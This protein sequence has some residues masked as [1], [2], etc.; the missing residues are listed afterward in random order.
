MKTSNLV[1]KYPRIC[2]KMRTKLTHETLCI[3]NIHQTVDSCSMKL[4]FCQLRV[5]VLHQ[6]AVTKLS[7]PIVF[8]H[9][10]LC[11]SS[12]VGENRL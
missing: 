11:H 12:S 10:L 3:L 6:V 8:H 5:L 7:A 2:L 4:Q 1:T 9:F